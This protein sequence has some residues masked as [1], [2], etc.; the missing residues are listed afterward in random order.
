VVT[1]S[2]GSQGQQCREESGA[3]LDGE[4]V[5]AAAQQSA[6]PEQRI[7]GVAAVPE[8]V[9]LGAAP[10]LIHA[11]Q[12]QFHDVKCGQHPDRLREL[13]GERR[14]VAA[15][16]IERGGHELRPELLVPGAETP[17]EHG[18]G[19]ALGDVQQTCGPAGGGVGDAGSRNSVRWVLQDRRNEAGPDRCDT[20]TERIIE[21]SVAALPRRGRC[22]PGLR[23]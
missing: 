6:G 14:R 15:E 22:G 20:E 13:G 17:G 4:P 16:R 10:N 21:G 19:A 23:F 7:L 2:F 3:L 9:L 5:G 18:A 12:R 1:S 8:G 11:G